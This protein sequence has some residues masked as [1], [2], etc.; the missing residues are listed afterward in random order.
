M[1]LTYPV[2]VKIVRIN[3]LTRVHMGHI[4]NAFDFGAEGVMLLGCEPDECHFC[5]DDKYIVNEY[6]KTQG[7]LEM[8]GIWKDRVTLVR[9]PA[10][11]GQRFVDEIMNLTREIEQIP[12][13]RCSK[14]IGARPVYDGST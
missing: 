4:L 14:I 1:G 5:S 11:N 3:C 10:F 7:I 13:S 2:S 8:M 9:L 12:S 6:K